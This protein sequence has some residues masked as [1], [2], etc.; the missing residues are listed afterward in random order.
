MCDLD[1]QHLLASHERLRMEAEAKDSS[2]QLREMAEKVFQLLE[3]LKLAELGKTKAVEALRQKEQEVLAIKKKNT[4]LIKES[5]AEGKAR[6]KAELD[7]KVLID[8]V[9][10]LKKH[11]KQ[12]ATRCREEVKGKLREHEDKKIAQ[13]K[14]RT[15]GGRL[16]FLLN[17][18]Q[19]DEEAKIVNK[20]RSKK[21]NAQ[22]TALRERSKEMQRKLDATSESNKIITK[23]MRTKQQQL[24]SLQIKF[25][26]LKRQLQE[27]RE[28]H[29]GASTLL[30]LCQVVVHTKTFQK[31]QSTLLLCSD[32]GQSVV[33]L[34]FQVVS[35]SS[36]GVSYF[37]DTRFLQ[38]LECLRHGLLLL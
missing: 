22:L 33:S 38:R 18:L 27:T 24:E 26:A 25:D 30:S 4:R 14:V 11:N 28:I 35:S 15:L 32:K 23:A 6:V 5:T 9:R 10:V 36:S 2:E 17:K 1:K 34:V 12:L 13:D 7:K 19:S 31:S 3:R 37:I 29:E 8:Q 20:E 21:T 16:S